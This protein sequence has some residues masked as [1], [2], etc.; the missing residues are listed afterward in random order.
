[1]CM[2]LLFR[3]MSLCHSDQSV[4]GVGFRVS[5]PNSK[6]H[7]KINHMATELEW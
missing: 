5:I 7:T 3:T 6:M 1:M 2:S 4:F